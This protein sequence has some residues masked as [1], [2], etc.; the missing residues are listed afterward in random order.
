MTKT[1]WR[2]LLISSGSLTLV[3]LLPY[4]PVLALAR[5]TATV[6]DGRTRRAAPADEWDARRAVADLQRPV[7]G[8]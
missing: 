1:A 7:L 6:G 8:R 3:A 4:P 5:R 2:D